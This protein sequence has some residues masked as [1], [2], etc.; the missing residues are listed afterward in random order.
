MPTLRPLALA[1]IAALTA[2]LISPASQAAKKSAHRKPA[3]VSAACS[4]FYAEA[5]KG[6]LTANPMPK[7]GA[8]SSL[9]QLTARA[10]QQQRDLLDNAQNAPQNNVQKLLGDFWASGMD[11]AAVEKDGAQPIAPLLSRINSIRSSKD[12][13]PAIA[14]LHQVGI[15]VAFQFAADVDL[16]DLNR[17][18]GYFNQGGIGLPDPAYYTRSDAE[19]QAL[20]ARY[21]D[22][23]RKILALTGVASKDIE[24]QTAF[25]L[26][27]EKRIAQH[28]RPL[29]DLRDPRNNFNPV[30]TASLGKQYKNLQLDAFL[31][32]QGVNDDTVSLANPALFSELNT[33]VARLKP[34][35]WQAYLRWRVGDAMAPYL[36]KSWREAAFDFR[37]KVLLGQSAPPPRW[38]QVL[39]AI[40]LAAGPMLGREYAATYLSDD[41]RK[42]AEHIAHQVLEAL[43]AKVANSPHWDAASKTEATNKLSATK[44]EIG[45][46][47]YDLDYTVQPMGRG[48]FGSNMLIASTWRH[49]QEMKRIGKAG[50]SRRWD[51]LP[52]VPSLA[53]DLAH[54]R[55]IATAAML[56]TPVL[57][58]SMPQGN[59]YG[60]FG[61]LVGHELT[62]AIDNI[63]QYVDA[64]GNV[65]EWWTAEDK[66]RWNTLIERVTTLYN[67][68]P[69]PGLPGETVDGRRTQAENL[70]DIAGLELA[71]TALDQALPKETQTV[72]AF[73]TGWAQLWAQQ[74]PTETAQL[75][76]EQDVRAPGQWRANAPIMLQPEF[77][78]AFGCK[79]GSSMQAKVSA[80][81]FD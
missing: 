21:A 69:Y 8:I 27:L 61:A 50:T 32:A 20:M 31:K 38:Q 41:T 55:L 6:W 22:S 26:D 60:A 36:S 64:S 35:Q 68:L 63:G 9:G 33:L 54:N 15:P 43:K 65:R 3:P 66:T 56:Q 48:S 37:G 46:P 11:E 73:Y 81:I 72:K 13:A 45:T 23:I 17:H 34:A 59:R 25:V 4:N 5:N 76:A 71:K 28:A 70:A 77:G 74:V 44:I 7:E 10:L 78:A 2:G 18:L 47:P 53:Y 12:I 57:D 75:R 49:T 79:P 39:N 42:Q 29:I 40:N 52:Q 30:P 51:V 24:T 16:R 1:L 62:H 14:A 67:G 80:Q 19:T 58:M